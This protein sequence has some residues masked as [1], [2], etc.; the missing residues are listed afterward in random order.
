MLPPV[1]APPVEKQE[2]VVMEDMVKLHTFF[3]EKEVKPNILTRAEFSRFEP[4]FQKNNNLTRQEIFDL[5]ET[6]RRTID[7]YNET[8]IVVSATDT[9]V[10]FTLPAL[11]TPV[12]TLSDTERNNAIATANARLFHNN[13]PR[14]G[15]EAFAN[16]ILA[17]RQEQVA[18][19]PV[20]DAYAENYVNCISQF[21]E[22]FPGAIPVV[23]KKEEIHVETASPT[24]WDAD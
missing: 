20:V 24:E 2:P 21:Y 7:I 4:L 13:V 19:K 5:S 15:A 18:N 17:I 8:A 6:Y 22:K 9:T 11:F 14:Y 12:R 23:N 10:L 1:K 3:K 16:M